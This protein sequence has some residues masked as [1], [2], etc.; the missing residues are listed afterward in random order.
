ME[1]FKRRGANQLFR[2]IRL[3]HPVGPGAEPGPPRNTRGSFY[4]FWA[5]QSHG[6][7]GL[8]QGKG[9]PRRRVRE[10][11]KMDLA[12]PK[13]AHLK[14]PG[15]KH[16]KLEKEGGLRGRRDGRKAFGS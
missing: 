16:L 15:G 6:T 4:R 2:E 3:G 12:R 9:R 1:G 11:V 14:T 13:K 10:A 7:P 8:Q 5:G